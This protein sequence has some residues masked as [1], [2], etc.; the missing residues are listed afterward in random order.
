[1]TNVAAKAGG[2][3][4]GGG[5]ALLDCLASFFAP[6][7]VQYVCEAE[8]KTKFDRMRAAAKTEAE[9]STPQRVSERRRRSG[10]SGGNGSRHKVPND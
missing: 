5:A 8:T 2:K 6:E 10:D 9:L 4:S 7:D 1:M 3:G